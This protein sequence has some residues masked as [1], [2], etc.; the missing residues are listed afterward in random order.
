LLEDVVPIEEQ[1]FLQTGITSTLEREDLA[2]VGTWGERNSKQSIGFYFL[3]VDPF[4]EQ[5]IKYL[6][7]GQLVHYLDNLNPKRAERIKSNSVND[8]AAGRIPNYTSYVMPYKVM[9]YKDGF[10]LLAEV[11]NP[12]SSMN[13]YYSN[14][15]YYNPYYNYGMYSMPNYYYPGMGRFRPYAYGNNMKT[16][17]EIKPTQTSLLSFDPKGKINWDHSFKIDEMKVAGVDQVSDFW[18]TDNLIYFL[19]KKESDLFMK[20]IDLS[21]DKGS[22]MVE[23]IKTSDEADVIRSEKEYEGGIRQWVGNS[24]YVWG[25]QT[26]RNANKE[27]RVRDVFYINKV[28][29]K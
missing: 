27:D 2:V 8:A 29:V 24:F 3:A 14:P 9:E 11:Y 26:I 12:I 4:N 22:Q 10:L 21:D 13:P 5:K 20:T 18:I 7:F 17:N 15:Y 25:Y 1:K 23:K 28:V 19:Y 16:V 6:D